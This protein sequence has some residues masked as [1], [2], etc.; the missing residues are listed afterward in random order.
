[1]T[2]LFLC[3][4]MVLLCFCGGLYGNRCW[5]TRNDY[6]T[7]RYFWTKYGSL[8]RTCDDVVYVTCML[9]AD[10]WAYTCMHTNAHKNVIIRSLAKA[11][12]LGYANTSFEGE[13]IRVRYHKCSIPTRDTSIIAPRSAS[14]A[15]RH[16]DVIEWKHFRVTGHLCGEFTGH[17]WIPRTKASDAEL[18]CFL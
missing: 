13:L 5:I 4:F 9:C 17:R 1:M 2:L 10:T 15:A 16:D 7:N 6:H 11:D 18:W 3:V 8:M 12:V 14:L